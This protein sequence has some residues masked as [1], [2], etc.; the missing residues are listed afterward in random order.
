[1]YAAG[2]EHLGPGYEKSGSALTVC[3]SRESKANQCI[4]REG[5]VADP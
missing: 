2:K 4:E 3:L 1:M 5:G